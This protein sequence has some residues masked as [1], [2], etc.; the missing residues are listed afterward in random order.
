MFRWALTRA[1]DAAELLGVDADLRKHWRDVAAQLAPYP[2]WKKPVGTVFSAMP[3]VEPRGLSRDHGFIA[4]AYPT[5]L[6]D[7]INLDSPQ[8]LKDLMARTVQNLPVGNVS[9]TLM[10]L[11]KS[12]NSAGG[13][14]GGGGGSMFGGG[15][16]L[17][18]EAMLNS[19]SGRIHLF[20]AVSPN[21]ELAFHNFQ[22][23]GGFL[24]SAAR[25]AGGVY[26]LEIQARRDL[27]CK[28]MNPWPGKS[29]MLH[30]TG[31]TEPVP[32]QIDRSNGECLL[33]AAV[34]NHKYQVE[35]K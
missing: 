10:L 11:G 21:A 15:G 17:D 23:R 22:A 18:P 2:T 28:L 5:L 7:E 29:V 25:N 27:L 33:F 34:A 13:R 16:G 14:R 32:V 8:E 6:A 24:V 30:E 20:P 12:S 19:R 3:D 1:A 4:V 9:G 26:Y 35:P 31:K